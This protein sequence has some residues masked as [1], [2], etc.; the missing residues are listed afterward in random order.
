MVGEAR[1]RRSAAPDTADAVVIGGGVM[2]C[3]LAYHLA[4]MNLRVTLCERDALGAQSSGRC[5]GGVRH[6]FSSEAN[7]RIQRLAVELL[8][9]F[10]EEVGFPCDFRQI[11]YLMLLSTPGEVGSF[12]RQLSMW[13]RVGVREARWVTPEEARQLVP[14]LSVE[15]ILGGTFCPTDG[16]ASPNDVTQGYASA[17]RRLG[18]RILEGTD[19]LSIRVRA[20]R[21]AGVETNGGMISSPIVVDCAGAWSASLTEP[22]GV[23]LPVAP[24]RRH[25]FVSEATPAVTPD[26]PMTV[27]VAT[28][29]YFHPEAGG[30][31]FG[32]GDADEQPT[33]DLGV[34]W[35]VLERVEG[36]ARRRVPELLNAGIRTAWAGLYEVTPDHNPFL[37]ALPDPSGLWCACGFSGHGFQQAPAVGLALSQM[38]TGAPVA[39]DLS[40]FSP[41]R[42]LAASLPEENFI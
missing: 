37:G 13:H 1:I 31:L 28:S 5:A 27:D 23:D 2:G 33:F 8:K 42:D 11:G 41:T 24:Y 18:A 12:R 25:V 22:L 38:I 19:V 30:A 36:V 20:G 39:V 14:S 32:I 35:S 7:V 26:T 6:Q 29:F 34:D 15:G 3:S 16:V 40:A 10:P 4:R 21:I 17:A 9:R